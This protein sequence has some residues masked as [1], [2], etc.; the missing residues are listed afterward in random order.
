MA[1]GLSLAASRDMPKRGFLEVLRDPPALVTGMSNTRISRAA[2]TVSTYCTVT[3]G[4]FLPLAVLFGTVGAHLL[5]S[6]CIFLIVPSLFGL[7]ML[8]AE[9]GS[10]QKNKVRE[11]LAEAAKA[12]VSGAKDVSISKY[13]TKEM[14]YQGGEEYIE[15]LTPQQQRWVQRE[16]DKA[17]KAAEKTAGESESQKVSRQL[18]SMLDKER[19]AEIV[20][21]NKALAEIRSKDKKPMTDAE[22]FEREMNSEIAR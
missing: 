10:Y 4:V 17:F 8:S 19:A 20:R 11:A 21:H 3:A 15:S 14:R 1:K 6:L 16:W 22:W 12:S 5:M 7:F 2:G 9:T 13:I 18:D